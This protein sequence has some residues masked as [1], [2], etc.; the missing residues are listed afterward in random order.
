MPKLV[1]FLEKNNAAIVVGQEQL[2]KDLLKGIIL[3][4]MDN[5]DKLT[6]MSRNSSILSRPEASHRLAMEILNAVKS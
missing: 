5:R 4:L 3:D 6:S 2:S 1:K